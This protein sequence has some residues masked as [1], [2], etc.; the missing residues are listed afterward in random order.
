M[1]NMRKQYKTYNLHLKHI[2][3]PE[4][5]MFDGLVSIVLEHLLSRLKLQNK[6]Q[7]KM[8]VAHEF[9]ARSI[10][11]G[12]Y[13]VFGS[14]HKQCKFAVPTSDGAYGR[15]DHQLTEY[16]HTAVLRVIEALE[17]LGWID[18]EKGFKNRSG[19]NIPTRLG[20]I[21]ELL[22]EFE[23]TKY[24]WRKMGP[25]HQDVIVLK[26]FDPRTKSKVQ[27]QSKDNNDIRR[28]RKNLQTYNSFI[29]EHAI[30]LSIDR[31][32]LEEGLITKMANDQYQLDSV[33][34]DNK[35]KPRIFNY[36]H[37][38][39]RRIFSRGSFQ[40]G[41]RFYGGWWQFIPSEYR[42]YI[43]INGLPTVEV[44]Y[45]EL[46][47][48]MMYR[49]ANLPLPEG[50]LYDLGLRYVDKEYDKDIEPYKSKRKVI[51]TYINAMI[52]DDRG[53][54]KLNH[55]QIKTMEMNTA[56]LG[57]LVIEKHPI[58]KDI[59]GKGHGLRY[60]FIDSQI[61]EKV[62][63]K[64]MSQGILCLPVHDS[65]IC[66]E[67][68]LTKLQL[69]MSEAYEEVLGIVPQLKEPEEHMTDF[70]PAYYPSGQLDLT[71]MKNQQQ[72]SQHDQFLSSYW[73]FQQKS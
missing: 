8:L 2:H 38:Q 3:L 29:T 56:S 24:V 31:H 12:L 19:E 57:A 21:G 41:G 11:E 40:K 26:D 61:A 71:Y 43:T 58:I 25:K 52:N 48:R 50:D 68:H 34:G 10:I 1:K 6:P 39:L 7:A 44:D 15:K 27:R 37:V 46:H 64:L 55:R 69:A 73:K 32:H 53:N 28:W 4:D 23:R 63:M 51:K 66:Q 30:C 35:K 72:D 54:F 45:S 60:Q 14:R 36:L 49:D 59:K 67:H 33:F 5:Q 22:Q 20:A 62:M 70:E 65:F 17:S 13:Q 16:S 47:P 42:R 9:A 18:R